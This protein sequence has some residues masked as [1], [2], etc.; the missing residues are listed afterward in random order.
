MDS[1][2]FSIF[3]LFLVIANNFIRGEF[4]YRNNIFAINVDFIVI[5]KIEAV[6]LIYWRMYNIAILHIF[7]NMSNS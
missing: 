2:V 4:I 5:V 3:K 6:S 1:I 7:S